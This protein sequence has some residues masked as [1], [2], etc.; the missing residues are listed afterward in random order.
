MF[1]IIN[2]NVVDFL[3]HERWSIAPRYQRAGIMTLRYL[4]ALGRDFFSGQ[5]TMRAMSLVYTTLLSIVPLLAF[6]FSVLKGFGIHKKLEPALLTMLEPLGPRSTEITA[7]LIALV[8]NVRGDWLATFGL[9]FLFFTV[10]SMIQKIEE[11]FN[12]VW[13]VETP[14]SFAQRFTEYI[15]VLLVGPVLMV[16]AMGAIASISNTSLVQQVA[17]I[18]PFGYWLV[19]LGKSMPYLMV[20]VVFTFV[21][22]FIPNTKV[23]LGAALVGGVTAGAIW[24]TLSMFFASAVAASPTRMAIYAGFAIGIVV[25]IWMYLNWIILLIG[26]QLSFY[27]QHPEYLR[28]GRAQINLPNRECELLALLTMELVG[29]DFLEGRPGPRI[30]DLAASMELPA[31]VLGPILHQ[32]E[33]AGLLRATENQHAVPGRSLDRITLSNIVDAVRNYPVNSYPSHPA[34]ERI[35]GLVD[36]MD[37]AIDTALSGQTLHGLV[38]EKYPETSPRL[39]SSGQSE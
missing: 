7:N 33:N 38:T 3:W 20:I 4:Y 36:S 6:S 1:P 8:D 13:Q 27:V 34:M 12:F 28:S 24:A 31:T 2:F 16:A 10:I 19:L 22:S 32:L 26:A 14:R 18:E 5:L 23:K 9:A 11:S 17:A 37:L 29:R 15:S 25:L 21:Y 30:D 35:R 39:P